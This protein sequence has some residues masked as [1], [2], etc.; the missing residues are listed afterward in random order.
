MYLY[1]AIGG[2]LGAMGRY[3]LGVLIMALAGSGFPYATLIVNIVGSF[4]MGVAIESFAVLWNP[5]GAMQIFITT[6]FLGAFTTFSTFSLDFISLYQRGDIGAALFYLLCSV[7]LSIV[8]LWAG[9]YII[10]FLN[11]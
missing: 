11:A 1:V 6:G 5:G 3:G 10:R 9:L 4:L 8:G 2:A 7:C